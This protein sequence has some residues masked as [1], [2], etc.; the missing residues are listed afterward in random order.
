MLVPGPEIN[1]FQKCCTGGKNFNIFHTTIDLNCVNKLC[2]HFRN[3]I[4]Y[5]VAMSDWYFAL[6]CQKIHKNRFIFSFL[7]THFPL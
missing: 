6:F 5:I 4:C 3:K 2:R 7:K 1:I